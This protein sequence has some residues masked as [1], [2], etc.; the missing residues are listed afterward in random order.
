V[1]EFRALFVSRTLSTIGD[2]V[3]RAG[4]VIAVFNE[5]KSTALL[6]ITF[7]LTSLPDLIGGPL[8]AG[9]ADRFPRRAVMVAADVGRAILLLVM[10]IPGQPLIAL[11]VLLFVIRLMDSPFLSAYHS[12]MSVVLPGKRQLVKG[13]AVTQ[14]VNHVSY[15]VG[16]GAG[17]L[18]VAL[19]GLSAVLIVNAG[20]F[21]LS[22]V[23]IL[24]GVVSRPATATGL[25]TWFGSTRTAVR[26]IFTHPRLR[27]V[28]LFT[29]PIAATLVVETLGAPYAAQLGGGPAIAG[30][31]MGASPAGIVLGLWLLPQLIPDQRAVHVA[32]LSILSGAPL[33]L[34]LLVPSAWLAVLLVVVGGLALYFW[35]PL[36]AEF[37]QTVPDEMRGQAVGLLTTTMRVTQGIAILTFGLVAQYASPSLVIAVGGA[38]G[39]VMAIALSAAWARTSEEPVADPQR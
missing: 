10:A 4:L 26:F 31:L 9:L 32:V 12:T 19:T 8:L 23:V 11:W 16:Y 35:I 17:G 34:F 38:L 3:A 25:E 18:V 13:S 20:T 6:G 1:R 21:V 30:L 5:T 37:T 27:L 2:Y 14:L 28:M 29:V 33:V 24:L 39:T 15:T 36:A 22:G 7:A